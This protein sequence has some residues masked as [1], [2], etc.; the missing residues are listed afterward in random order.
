MPSVGDNVVM[1]TE[2][3]ALVEQFG[4]ELGVRAGFSSETTLQIDNDEAVD[5]VPLNN[6][7][8]ENPSGQF[9]AGTGKWYVPED[10]IYILTAAGEFFPADDDDGKGTV[11]V[12]LQ[13]NGT[14]V[15]QS[16]G[17]IAT[18]T[19][20]SNGDTHRT[21]AGSFELQEGDYISLRAV[22]RTGQPIDFGG[23]SPNDIFYTATKVGDIP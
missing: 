13:V 19:G 5:P 18:A 7:E 4:A 8:R 22:N 12:A 1:L 23:D 20:T 21:C 11:N 2:T 6:T 16:Q 15:Q 10:G 9:E 14:S 17:P 3:T